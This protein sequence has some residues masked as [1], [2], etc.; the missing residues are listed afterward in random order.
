MHKIVLC[1]RLGNVLFLLISFVLV[2]YLYHNTVT[3]A[4]VNCDIRMAAIM[5]FVLKYFTL[6]ISLQRFDLPSFLSNDDLE[7]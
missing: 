6:I 2:A 4:N 7:L 1:G 3:Y 5:M